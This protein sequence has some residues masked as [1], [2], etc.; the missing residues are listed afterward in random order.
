MGV[1]SIVDIQQRLREKAKST[2]KGEWLVGV[3]E[4]D[5]KLAEKR[6]PDRWARARDLTIVDGEVVYTREAN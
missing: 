1:K 6:H 4:D 5:S 3:R 2:P